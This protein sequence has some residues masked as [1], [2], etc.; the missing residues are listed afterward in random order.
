MSRRHQQN[1]R[2]SY[3]RRQHEVRERRERLESSLRDEPQPAFVAGIEAAADR[4]GRLAFVSAG[5]GWADGAA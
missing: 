1:R 4:L 5:L 3:G 2:R